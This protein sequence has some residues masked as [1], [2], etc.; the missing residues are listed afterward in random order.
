[1]A[2][3]LVA[4]VFDSEERILAAAR[5]A[6]RAGLPIHDAYTPFAVHGLDR[7]LGLEPSHLGVVCFRFGAAG[8]ILTLGF[9][10]W[11]STFDWPMNIGGKSLNASPALI[12][13]AFELTV[14]FAGV[15]MVLWFLAMRGLSP[16]KKPALEALGGVDD[17]FVLALRREPGGPSGEALRR[18]L[19][20]QGAQLVVDAEGS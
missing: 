16:V 3:E 18:F 12:P 17:R 11:A 19:E 20:A 9:Q 2:H 10:Y 4:G 15:G 1:M 14:L 8:L 7:E 6:R 13:V 5:A